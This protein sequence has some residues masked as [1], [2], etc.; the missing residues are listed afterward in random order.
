VPTMIQTRR[1]P[2]W[3]AI[4]GY[5]IRYRSTFREIACIV[6]VRGRGSVGPRRI[7]RGVETPTYELLPLSVPYGPPSS[8]PLLHRR[9]GP[10]VVLIAN[11]T[12][13]AGQ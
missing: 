5:S 10:F 6:C 13:A 12:D 4:G 11:L 3:I 7:R 9:W 2:D 1:I 8:P